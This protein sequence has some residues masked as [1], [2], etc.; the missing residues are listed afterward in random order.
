M[1]E[2]EEALFSRWKEGLRY[3]FSIVG[4][5]GNGEWIMRQYKLALIGFGNVGRGFVQILRDRGAEIERDFGVRAVVV[6]VSDIQLGCVYDPEGFSPAALLDAFEQTG[7]LKG[8]SAPHTGWDARGTIRE[9]NADVVVEAA[10]TDLRTGE[11]AVGHIRAALEAGKHAITTNKGPAALRYT[12]L[13]ALAAARGVVFG[14]EGTVMSGTPA[15]RLATDILAAAGI[16]KIQGILNGTTNFIL[17]RMHAGGDYAAAL[18]EAQSLGYA[19]AD[20]SGDVEGIDAAGKLI[21]LAQVLMKES[22]ALRDIEPEGITRLTPEDMRNAEQAGERWKLIA[23]L[24][25]KDYGLT[26]S[27]A[28]RRLPLSH[29]LAAV[30]GATN[31]ITYTTDLLG[32]VTLIGPGAGRLET[33]YAIL[34]DLL[35]IDRIRGAKA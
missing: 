6:A 2:M 21:I 33:G 23:G 7:S 28:P 8:V 27:V 3:N 19:E 13:A 24:E 10:W 16:R 22:I 14:V 4:F 5:P 18:K 29:P 31:A 35:A 34:S 15:L 11:P 26:A 30:S 20:P 12:E 9:T 32:D 17:T 25:R 1:P